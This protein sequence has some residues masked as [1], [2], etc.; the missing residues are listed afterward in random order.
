MNY[1]PARLARMGWKEL[2]ASL[3]GSVAPI[4]GAATWPVVVLILILILTTRF[5]PQIE[6]LLDRLKT[7]QVPGFVISFSE[8][9]EEAEIQAETVLRD[10]KSRVDPEPFESEPAE[11]EPRAPIRDPFAA[12]VSAWET[13][14]TQFVE[15]Q[16]VA[17]EAGPFKS[18]PGLALSKLLQADV[19]SAHAAQTIQSLRRLRNEVAH[20][21]TVPTVDEADQFV[22]AAADMTRYAKILT[23]GYRA[24]DGN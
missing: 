20:G 14:V 12:I 2:V 9:V 22:E 3:V 23:N 18:Y 19:V 17:L 13:L 8:R 5:R 16:K 10:A 24:P 1:Q 21:V 4:F 11:S 7:A 6:S 15:L